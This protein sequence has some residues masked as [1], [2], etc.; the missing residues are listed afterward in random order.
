[1]ERNTYELFLESKYEP[2]AQN[3]DISRASIIPG[4]EAFLRLVAAQVK[5]MLVTNPE[6]R[7]G[8]SFGLCKQYR[9]LQQ[10]LPTL[11]LQVGGGT[12]WAVEALSAFLPIDVVFERVYIVD[13]TISFLKVARLRIKRLGLRNVRIIH[14]DASQFRLSEWEARESNKRDHAELITMSHALSIMPDFYPVADMCEKMLSPDGIIAVV[15]FCL[16]N[17]EDVLS[18]NYTAG[19]QNRHSR[20][21]K[22]AFFLALAE[23]DRTG[24]DANRQ[25]YLEYK[26]GN[27]L[28]LHSWEF[29]WRFIPYYAWLGC[30]Q[31]HRSQLYDEVVA[32]ATTEQGLPTSCRIGRRSLYEDVRKN[33]RLSCLYLRMYI[34]IIHGA[35]R[36]PIN[37]S[38]LLPLPI[39]IQRQPQ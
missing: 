25:N 11:T 19:F 4:R 38:T 14:A 33:F 30:K 26:F 7:R 24:A 28:G 5:H 36:S 32:Q 18:R 2:Q 37:G 6:L 31:R 17:V 9:Q 23:G 39:L 22:R 20:W 15:D 29:H 21:L 27:I 13:L 10:D 1:M 3:Y 12:G 35:C 34:R 16:A 8:N